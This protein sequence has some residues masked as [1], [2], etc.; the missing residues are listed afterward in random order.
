MWQPIL[1]T[2][3]E[4]GPWGLIVILLAIAVWLYATDR[5]VSA[6]RHRI[7]VEDRDYW[8]DTALRALNIGEAAV[9][10]SKDGEADG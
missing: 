1:K 9:A 5:I 6:G 2:L 4:V 3:A 7:M 10:R 8:R